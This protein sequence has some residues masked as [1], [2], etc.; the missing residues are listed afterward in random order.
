[1]PPGLES[2]L[3]GESILPGAG[4]HVR[5]QGSWSICRRITATRSELASANRVPGTLWRR[6]TEPASSPCRCAP[7]QANVIKYFIAARRY[8]SFTVAA[9]PE[10]SLRKDLLDWPMLPRIYHFYVAHLCRATAATAVVA[11]KLSLTI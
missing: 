2:P 11:Y 9:Q 10:V 6:S 4:I 5:Q 1:V 3:R 7:Q 8:R